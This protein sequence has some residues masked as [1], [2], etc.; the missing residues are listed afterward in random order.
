MELP[1]PCFNLSE[2][3]RVRLLEARYEA[4]IAVNMVKEGLVKNVAISTGL[5]NELGKVYGRKVKVR[6]LRGKD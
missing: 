3:R 6:E 2:Y 1:K 5:I 4:E